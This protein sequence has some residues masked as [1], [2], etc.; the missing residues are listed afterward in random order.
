MQA[1]AEISE[2]GK[3]KLVHSREWEDFWVGRWDFAGLV[4]AAIKYRGSGSGEWKS[5]EF[6]NRIPAVLVHA[7]CL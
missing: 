2:K 5:V 7:D 6:G 1:R 3:G 4:V